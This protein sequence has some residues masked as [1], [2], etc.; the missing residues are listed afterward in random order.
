MEQKKLQN[1]KK[2]SR[3]LRKWGREKETERT[4]THTHIHTTGYT[5]S[6]SQKNS[7]A[8][9]QKS[10]SAGWLAGWLVGWLASSPTEEETYPTSSCLAFLLPCCNVELW[11]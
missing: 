3:S 11:R 6:A 2:H 7:N 1:R 10:P 4:R 8:E 5:Q 9:V